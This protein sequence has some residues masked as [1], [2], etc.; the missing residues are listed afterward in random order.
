MDEVRFLLLEL[1]LVYV[2][3]GTLSHRIKNSLSVKK[4]SSL[5]CGPQG[6]FLA[7][8]GALRCIYLSHPPQG[9][10]PIRFPQCVLHLIADACDNR[11]SVVLVTL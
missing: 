10:I 3:D 4:T 7:W 2:V 6:G 1:M 8:F 9:V 5:V 11:L